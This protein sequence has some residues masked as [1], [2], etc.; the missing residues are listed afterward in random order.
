MDEGELRKQLE[1]HHAVCLG[2]TLN[3]CSDMPELAED[4]LQAVYLK[5]LQGRAN[6]HGRAA[7]KTWLF[8]VIR[9]TA[10][11]E[12][13]RVWLR[14][15]W[16]GRQ[17]PEPDIQ[18]PVGSDYLDRSERLDAF[19]KVLER[20][21]TRQ[22]EALHLVFYQ[23]LT[24]EEAAEVMGVSLGAVRQ[25]YERGKKNLRERLDRS[26]LFYERGK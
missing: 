11:A 10:L 4:V 24:L 12:R 5:I 23:D 2:W 6:Y 15:L 7:F 13:R 3:C 18:P 14:R 26:E 20:L 16:L 19:R 21:S 8:A 1:Q 9:L 22:R 17:E 25:H